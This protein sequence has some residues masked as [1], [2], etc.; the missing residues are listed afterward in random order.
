[1]TGMSPSMV[2]PSRPKLSSATGRNPTA[3]LHLDS[4]ELLPEVP[5]ELIFLFRASLE[6]L[7][8]QSAAALGDHSQPAWPT[9]AVSNIGEL[10]YEIPYHFSILYADA[11][12]PGSLCRQRFGPQD[13]RAPMSRGRR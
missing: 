5:I 11:R 2:N 7:G 3:S 10:P 12:A 13:R 4:G 1:M 9:A 6:L 8:R